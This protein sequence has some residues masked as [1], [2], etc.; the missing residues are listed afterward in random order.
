[1]E[2]LVESVEG[3]VLDFG[4]EHFGELLLNPVSLIVEGG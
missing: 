1:M 4:L 3:K 2:F